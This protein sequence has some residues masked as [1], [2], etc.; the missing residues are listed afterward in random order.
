MGFE[1]D[2]LIGLFVKKCGLMGFHHDDSND[3]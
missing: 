3:D 2:G 1:L